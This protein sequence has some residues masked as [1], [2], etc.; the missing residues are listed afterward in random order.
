LRP[1]PFMGTL[2]RRERLP[3]NH[4]GSVGERNWPIG[5]LV[6]GEQPAD[7]MMQTTPWVRSCAV[8]RCPIACGSSPGRNPTAEGNDIENVEHSQNVGHQQ[9]R[10]IPT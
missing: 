6:R 2:P 4:L 3:N 1:R 8:R 7:A 10:L 9:G 5:A